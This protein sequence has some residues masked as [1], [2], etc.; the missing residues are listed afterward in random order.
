MSKTMTACDA[1]RILG[2][3]VTTILTESDVRQAFAQRVRSIHPDTSLG[4]GQCSIAEM[5]HA[6]DYLLDQLKAEENACKNCNGWGKVRGVMGWRP[7]DACDGS[8]DR[9]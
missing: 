7:C 6:R 5:Q 2:L 1:A 4:I 8:G 9:R 3:N